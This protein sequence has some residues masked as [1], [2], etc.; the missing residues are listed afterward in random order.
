MVVVVV[1]IDGNGGGGYDRNGGGGGGYEGNGGGGL[2]ILV[3]LYADKLS[4]H[5][6]C[7]APLFCT[8]CSD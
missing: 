1:V 8:V 3:R 7:I 2:C 6:A 4:F 5:P